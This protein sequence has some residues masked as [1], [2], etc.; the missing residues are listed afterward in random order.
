MQGFFRN[1][2]GEHARDA[3]RSGVG[4]LGALGLIVL[5]ASV[6]LLSLPAC[7]ECDSDFDPVKCQDLCDQEWPHADCAQCRGDS[8]AG[9]CP[10]C[11]PGP[12]RS[13]KCPSLAGG[14]G[15]TSGGSGGSSGSTGGT[16]GMT[17][18]DG[19]VAGTISGGAGGVTGGVGGSTGGSGGG[20]VLPVDCDGNDECPYQA[21][22][23]EGG[24]CVACDDHDACELHDPLTL[25]DAAGNEGPA[26]ECV[27][28][29]G[30]EQ[31][32]SET[33]HCVDGACKE[34]EAHTDCSDAS[35]PECSADHVCVPCTGQPAC[36]ERG[37]RSEC[38]MRD[39]SAT[40]GQCVECLEHGHCTTAAAPQCHSASGSCVACT[41]NDAC[42][43][44]MDGEIAIEQCNTRAGKA[45]SGQCVQCVGD[46][47][48]EPAATTCVGTF[49]YACDQDLGRCTTR[50]VGTTDICTSC[51]ADSECEQEAKCVTLT[52]G[53]QTFGNYCLHDK[54]EQ[55]NACGDTSSSMRPY[56]RSVGG[57]SIDGF[58]GT[59]CFPSTSCEAI[60]DATSGTFT[61]GKV[62]TSD[63]MCGRG[64]PSVDGA[65]CTNFG[66]VDDRCS[67]TCDA[68]HDCP[69]GTYNSCPESAGLRY[70][71]PD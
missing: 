70:C 65:V 67:Y 62:C 46:S 29:L 40:S 50:R 13:D 35:R 20:V 63:T 45:T 30:N 71:Q 55:S 66:G 17:G 37:A 21:A 26:G 51:V 44:R 27:Q 12:G 1:P 6:V 7:N 41:A 33:P 22:R 47:A 18:G 24:K 9:N 69:N 60:L 16:G 8:L 57:T 38:D 4:A 14:S 58:E 31:C 28:C 49:S 3:W 19:G 2:S 23:C 34:C 43:G 25:C 59:F 54:A 68:S 61:T 5:T 52:L 56:N 10:Q 42:A 48:T 36:V 64:T 15:G 32:A 11:L 53:A 39:G